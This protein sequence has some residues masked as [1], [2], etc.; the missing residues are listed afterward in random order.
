[1]GKQYGKYGR[2]EMAKRRENEEDVMNVTNRF[3]SELER[4]ISWNQGELRID[5]KA[6][7]KNREKI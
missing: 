1:L 5:G 6:D 4:F 3:I 7:Q 2:M